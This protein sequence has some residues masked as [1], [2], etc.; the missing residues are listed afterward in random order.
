MPTDERVESWVIGHRGEMK[1]SELHTWRKRHNLSSWKAAADALGL[2]YWR[3]LR[4]KNGDDKIPLQ[5]ELACINFECDKFAEAVTNKAVSYFEVLRYTW[6]CERIIKVIE[7]P[8]G[9]ERREELGVSLLLGL[10]AV[11]ADDF[12]T[13]VAAILRRALSRASAQGTAPSAHKVEPSRSASHS[14]PR[15][16]GAQTAR[17]VFS[18]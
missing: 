7:L 13:T 9:D 11:I 8:H 10:I 18:E 2:P 16:G 5:I 3:M 17:R 4:L 14:D 15:L 1:S 6:F 12:D